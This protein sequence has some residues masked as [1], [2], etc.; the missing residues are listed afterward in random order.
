METKNLEL[1]NLETENLELENKEYARLKKV[2]TNEAAV[3]K[4]LMSY[5]EEGI[6]GDIYKCEIVS[7]ES[8]DLTVLLARVQASMNVSCSVGFDRTE[9]YTAQEKKYLKQGDRYYSGNVQRYAEKDGTYTIDVIKTRTVTDWQPYSQQVNEGTL[10]YKLLNQGILNDSNNSAIASSVVKYMYSTRGR[11]DIYE[12]IGDV[13]LIKETQADL[14]FVE[15]AGVKA[16]FYGTLRSAPGDHYKQESS[17]NVNSH[18]EHTLKLIAPFV[19]VVVSYN[20][21]TYTYI[22]PTFT[23]DFSYNADKSVSGNKNTDQSLIIDK[24]KY[25]N[26]ARTKYGKLS[27]AGLITL[28]VGIV[29][30]GLLSIWL[31]FA[32][33]LIVLCVIGAAVCFVLYNKKV[34][35]Y[36]K[37]LYE[38]HANELLLQ[39]LNDCE[40]LLET[41]GFDPLTEEERE[42][43]NRK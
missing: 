11:D 22:I 40:K 21:E 35:I 27:L 28:G 26:E 31:S 12:P 34:A 1:E 24:K 2:I 20:G 29:G 42:K 13:E 16:I 14:D 18:I 8:I 41:L 32:P 7:T 43:F 10:S 6:P 4:L 37:Q 5:T 17:T 15:T 25:E 38:K 23:E 9:E 39:K 36:S 19:K 33:M 3:R 30:G